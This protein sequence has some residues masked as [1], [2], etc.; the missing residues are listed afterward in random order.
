MNNP[1]T[2]SISTRSGRNYAP[3]NPLIDLAKKGQGKQPTNSLNEDL[4][5]IFS[6]KSTHEQVTWRDIYSA[7]QLVDLM[8]QG[9]PPSKRNPNTGLWIPQAFPNDPMQKRWI[10]TMRFYE[11]MLLARWQSS[12]P[13]VIIKATGDDD[14]DRMAAKNA[15]PVLDEYENRFFKNDFSEREGGMALR[16]GMYIHHIYYDGAQKAIKGLRR[17][18]ENTD[19][20][21]G[22]GDGYCGECEYAGEAKDFQEVPGVLK[23]YACPQC[24]STATNVQPPAELQGVQGGA[25]EEEVYTGDIRL[26]LWPLQSLRWDLTGKPEESSWLIHRQRTS[27]SKIRAVL[28]SILLKGSDTSDI[29]LESLEKLA[30]VGVPISGQSSGGQRKPSI[31]KDPVNVEEMYLDA[32]EVADI[33]LGKIEKTVDGEELPAN[34]PLSD[35]FPNGLVV[36]GLNSMNVITG[37]YAESHRESIVTGY[38]HRN[39]NSGIGDGVGDAVEVEKRA[40]TLDS[41]FISGM[42]AYSTPGF[43]HVK[44]VLEE[45][46]RTYLGTPNVN[47]AIDT[48]GL[49]ADM[50]GDLGKLVRPAYEPRSVPTQMLEYVQ[51]FLRGAMQLTMGV[52]EFSDALPGQAGRNDTATGA[53]IEAEVSRMMSTPTLQGK[54]ASRVR[55]A[56]IIIG[57]F[58]VNMVLKQ[59]FAMPGIRGRQQFK[60]L[61]AGDIKGKLRFETVPN[62]EI[63]RHLYEKIRDLD[64]FY[65]VF[66]GYPGYLQ[67][68][69]MFPKEV[70]EEARRRNIKLEESDYD[71]LTELCLNRLDQMRE[72]VQRTQVPQDLLL[73]IQPPISQFESLLDVQTKWWQDYLNTQQGQGEPM[74]VRSAIELIIQGQFWAATQTE[75]AM[76]LRQGIA[77]AAQQAPE[78]L[79]SQLLQGSDGSQQQADQQAVQDDAQFQRDSQLKAQ[80]GQEAYFQR[81]HE[82]SENALNRKHEQRMKGQDMQMK[83]KELAA[84]KQMRKGEGVAA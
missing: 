47:F 56:E 7:S 69:Q 29:G 5:S 64:G 53:Q 71:E 13:D 78:A 70:M 17:I 19:L 50:R 61:A 66:G 3:L 45:N 65:A 72:G 83:L 46:E 59:S 60:W 39:P 34:V 84:Q 58:Q 2:Q 67:A 33:K 31:Y 15:N 12:N 73:L 49:P 57:L 21:L 35:L 48:T 32:S 30:Y 11:S 9:K 22:G 16:S 42:Q 23:T 44:G 26:D 4:K 81:A 75:A 82:A 28:G 68:R 36:C 14:R 8:I 40:N 63:A 24:G 74:I 80:D 52:T 43:L 27:L 6:Y 18:M 41:Q 55:D 20:T 77:Q 62:S 54:A 1:P 79:G 51:S 25:R 38:W 10:N 76:G 37:I